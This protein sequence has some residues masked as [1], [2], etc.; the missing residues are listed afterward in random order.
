MDTLTKYKHSKLLST[1]KDGVNMHA[2]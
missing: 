1:Q 2:V